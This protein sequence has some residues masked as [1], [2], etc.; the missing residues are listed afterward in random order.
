MIM[1]MIISISIIFIVNTRTQCT[2]PRLANSVKP[3]L[4][5]LLEDEPKLKDKQ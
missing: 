5:L 2:S 4:A 3:R 1:I